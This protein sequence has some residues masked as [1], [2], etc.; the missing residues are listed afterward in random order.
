M[1]IC[2]AIQDGHASPT[3]C[4][5]CCFAGAFDTEAEVGASS[6]AVNSVPYWASQSWIS[7]QSHSGDL[8][9]AC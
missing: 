2:Q 6:N 1:S 4:L 8:H 5:V 3:S 9:T 7:E